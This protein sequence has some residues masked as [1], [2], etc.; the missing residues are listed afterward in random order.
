LNFAAQLDARVQFTAFKAA[1]AL[2][3]IV[4]ITSILEVAKATDK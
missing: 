1:V 4:P 3:I 2:I